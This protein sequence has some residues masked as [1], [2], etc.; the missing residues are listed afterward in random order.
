L[1]YVTNITAMPD[2][3]IIFTGS[4]INLET[5][6]GLTVNEQPIPVAATS[7]EVQTKTVRANPVWYY[8]NKR[9]RSIQTTHY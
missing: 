9:N 4:D 1:A 5:I 8:P 7:N 3:I 2:K 6:F